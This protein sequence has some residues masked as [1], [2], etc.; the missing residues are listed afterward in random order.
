MWLEETISPSTSS[1]GCTIVSK[2][3][4][5]ASSRGSP[6]ALWPKRKFSP[7]DTCAGAERADEHVV[8][9][10]P[11]RSAAANSASKGITISSRT[12]SE[13]ISSALRSSV[14]SSLG[15]CWGATTDT[16]CGSNVS[17]LSAPVIT[18][19]WPR[20]TPS[21]VPTA[22]L[23]AAARSTSGRRVTF[24]A[25]QTIWRARRAPDR[26][27]SRGGSRHGSPRGGGATASRTSNGP[28]AVRLQLQAVGVAEVGDQRAHVG[29]GAALDREA[30]ARQLA[31]AAGRA[32]RAGR[33][34]AARSDDTVT[35][36]SG[37][38]KRSP[39]RARL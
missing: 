29:A 27:R 21:K 8:D 32:A 18:S 31:R 36:R 37:I 1:S 26:A 4:S 33:A 6:C 23:R 28:I 35:I 2:R 25:A 12:P 3:S 13:A 11:A 17:T 30:R 9:E 24:T 39:R 34:T 14:V 10:L 7:I 20:C 19:R 38:S 22:T 5:A 16:G 15:V